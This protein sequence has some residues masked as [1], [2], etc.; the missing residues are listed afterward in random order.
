ME[1][2]QCFPFPNYM[3]AGCQLEPLKRIPADG[4]TQVR[5]RCALAS[6]F[7]REACASEDA[8]AVS[9]R[10]L[11]PEKTKASVAGRRLLRRTS[12][13]FKRKK[14]FLSKLNRAFRV[15]SS[16]LDPWIINGLV[17]VNVCRIGRLGIDEAKE[18]HFFLK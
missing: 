10:T 15:L 12:L 18:V 13:F 16:S 3:A 7:P 9:S 2:P 5:H 11:H 4:R 1:T 14:P 17:Y 6:Y 8:L